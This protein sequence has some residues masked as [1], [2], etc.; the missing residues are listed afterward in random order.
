ML[1][2]CVLALDALM[3]L[4]TGRVHVGLLR[5]GPGRSRVLL[6]CVGPGRANVLLCV[7]TLCF[8]SIEQRT[9]EMKR[10]SLLARV[11]FR[12]GFLHSL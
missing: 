10:Y 7:F 9:A 2:C 6:L 8:F 12:A 3:Y 5:V 1:V 4:C 11:Y